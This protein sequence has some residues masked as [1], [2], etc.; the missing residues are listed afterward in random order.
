MQKTMNIDGYTAHKEKI[1]ET[2]FKIVA[3]KEGKR[4]GLKI[5]GALDRRKID[6][7]I[8][9]EDYLASKKLH[10]TQIT[11]KIDGKYYINE[12]KAFVR[13]DGEIKLSCKNG[14]LTLIVP[15]QDYIAFLDENRIDELLEEVA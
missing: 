7:R 11:R 3:W 12:K 5:I 2:H 6:T 15:E 8:D 4:R 1:R 14:C 9:Y 10:E 13:Y